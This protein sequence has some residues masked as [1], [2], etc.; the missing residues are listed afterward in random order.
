MLIE[1]KSPVDTT[2]KERTTPLHH[3]ALNGHLKVVRILLEN[4]AST[5]VQDVNGNSPLDLAILTD[6]E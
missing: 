5:D 6:H 1:A 3:A 4:G 2:D